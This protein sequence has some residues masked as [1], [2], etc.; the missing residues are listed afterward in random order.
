MSSVM[1]GFSGTPWGREVPRVP[2]SPASVTGTWI[3]MPWAT[4]T[5]CPAG[6]CAACTTQW[7]IT[8]SGVGRAST[9]MRWLPALLGSVHV[10]TAPGH[11]SFAAQILPAEGGRGFPAG[12]GAD[13]WSRLLPPVPECPLPSCS[14]AILPQRYSG[15]RG[16]FLLEPWLIGE[17]GSPRCQELSLSAPFLQS[18]PPAPCWDLRV[19]LSPTACDCNPS[20]SDPRLEGCD[21]GTGQCHCLPHVT[22]RACGQCQRGYYSLEPTVGCK[23]YVGHGLGLPGGQQWLHVP[24]SALCLLMTLHFS[25]QL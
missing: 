24:S 15:L 3:S 4:V 19:I 12:L 2:V 7:V 1:T 20:G 6:A 8:A 25:C 10:R 23:R 17:C 16:L 22:G 11:S 14:S 21:P 5:P 13:G 18:Y 9:G